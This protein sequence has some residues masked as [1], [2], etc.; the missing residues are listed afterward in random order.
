MAAR[1]G[2]AFAI[3]ADIS[4]AHRRYLRGPHDWGL[5]ACL[6]DARG[7]SVAELRRHLRRGSSFL[8]VVA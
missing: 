4:K 6:S 1:G 5:M 3:A 8:L 2:A 7:P